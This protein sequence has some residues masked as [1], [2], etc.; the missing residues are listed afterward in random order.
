MDHIEEDSSTKIT[1][2]II[3]TVYVSKLEPVPKLKHQQTLV[4]F[5]QRNKVDKK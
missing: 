1:K 4:K 5:G 3:S 2:L